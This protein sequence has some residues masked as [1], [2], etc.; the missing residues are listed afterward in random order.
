VNK[1]QLDRLVRITGDLEDVVL[2]NE[3]MSRSEID[4]KI[5]SIYIRMTETIGALMLDMDEPNGVLE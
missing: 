2:N 1:R 4:M 3:S 5:S